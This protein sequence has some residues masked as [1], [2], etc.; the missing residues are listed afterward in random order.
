MRAKKIA[1][2]IHTR[3]LS[4]VP[5]TGHGSRMLHRTVVQMLA[6]KA[7]VPGRLRATRQLIDE[8][9]ISYLSAYAP[10]GWTS[11]RALVRQMLGA[12]RNA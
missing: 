8:T 4:A 5:H 11:H 6:A 1:F 12:R 3:I 2:R 9:N 10:A 7:I